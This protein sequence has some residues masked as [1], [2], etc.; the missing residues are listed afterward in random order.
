MGVL[1]SLLRRLNDA[2]HLTS[3]LVSH[4]VMET[5]SIADFAYVISEGKVVESGTPE[6][7]S[8]TQSEWVKQF[9]NGLSDGPVPFHYPADDLYD[10]LLSGDKT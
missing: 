4:D 8:E 6:A 5:L 10:D 1:V 9:L 7:L 3:I 2:L